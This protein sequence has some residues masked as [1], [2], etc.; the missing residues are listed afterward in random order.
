M[1]WKPTRLTPEQMEERRVQAGQML[2][3]RK[4]SKA[5]I[6]RQMGVS[7]MAVTQWAKQLAKGGL[8]RLRR[9]KRSGRPPKLNREQRKILRRLLKRGAKAFGFR[10]DRWTLHRIQ[11]VIEREFHVVYHPNYVARILDQMGWSLRVPRP[12]AKERDEALIRAW[13]E[14]DWPRIKKGAAEKR[15]DRVFR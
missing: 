3:R 9:R 6:A 1:E 5:E 11:R 2:R 13:L 7:R 15:N 8:R 10:S 4:L 14:K 12:R